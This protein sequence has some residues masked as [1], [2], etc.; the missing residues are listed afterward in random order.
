MT[1]LHLDPRA[2]KCAVSI[3]QVLDARGLAG[4]LR[5][6]GP[7]L[8]G[9]CPL[10][11]GDNPH[12]FVVHPDKNLW[13]CFTGCRGGGDVI[14]LVQRLDHASFP[15]ALRTLAGLAR[16]AAP[17][18]PASDPTPNAAAF[19]AY[20]RALPL[21]ASTPFLRAKG[22]DP[23]TARAFETGAYAGTGFLHRCVAVRLHDTGG[24]PIGYAGR[25]LHPDDCRR[26]GKWKLPPRLPKHQ[27]LFNLHRVRRD[28][29]M[30]GVVLVECPW[31]VMRLA[32]LGV[33]AVALLGTALSR[34]QRD[35]LAS[36]TRVLILLDG[37]PAG[38]AAAHHILDAL[39]SR[40][41]T[42]IAH[43]PDGC[44]P[45]DLDGHELRRAVL[46]LHD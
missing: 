43:L 8:V 37:D 7:R 10:H 36:A 2:L 40:T 24:A 15:E 29:A 42:R 26:F 27:L 46:P 12:A 28:L 18:D 44:D 3:F 19:R 1:G 5:R 25:H 20:T 39:P 33:P 14:D 41:R 45:D 23:S 4:Q 17:A 11:G 34:P 32:Q 22:I 9:P 21:D 30:T 31:G 35:L 13:Y 6:S 38:R 16:N